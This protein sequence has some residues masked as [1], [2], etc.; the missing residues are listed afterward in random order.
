MGDKV[1]LSLRTYRTNRPSQK[2]DDQ[3]AGPFLIIKKV[4]NSF[5]LDLPSSI[6]I[7]PV[8]SP[9]KLRKATDEDPLPG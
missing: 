1:Y 7:H 8:I 5:K 4:G 6:K 9:D 3:Q 2:L